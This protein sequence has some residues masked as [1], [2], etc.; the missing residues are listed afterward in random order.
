MGSATVV[1]NSSNWDIEVADCDQPVL[2]DFWAPWCSPCKAL[3]PTI[4]AVATEFAGQIKVVKVNIDDSKDLAAS[5]GVR[6]IP[7]LILLQRGALVAL[8]LGRTRTRIVVE[9]EQQLA[10]TR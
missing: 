1:V 5:F 2:V 4:D 10:S 9:L 3:E 7:S 6:G 8:V